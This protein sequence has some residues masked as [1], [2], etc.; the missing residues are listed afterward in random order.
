MAF[1]KKDFGPL[2]MVNYMS[3][4][5]F[6]PVLTHLETPNAYLG[7]QGGEIS[8]LPTSQSGRGVW[9]EESPSH[10]IIIVSEAS[11]AK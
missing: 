6:H 3:L 2:G 1:S 11:K 5:H 10:G 9:I 4:V 7:C 8:E